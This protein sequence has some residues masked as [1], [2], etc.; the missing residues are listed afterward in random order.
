M[1]P[2]PDPTKKEEHAEKMRAIWAKR[3]SGELPPPKKREP[4]PKIELKGALQPQLQNGHGIQ[5]EKS[6]SLLARCKIPAAEL[7]AAAHLQLIEL[8]RIPVEDLKVELHDK[9]RLLQIE[10][11]AIH[12]SNRAPLAGCAR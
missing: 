9:I 5:T 12:L 11:E 1:R 10:R 2:K 6:E 3:N 8:I 4:R 7:I